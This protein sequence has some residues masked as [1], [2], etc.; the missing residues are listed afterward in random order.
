M[1]HNLLSGRRNMSSL[2]PVSAANEVEMET[3]DASPAHFLIKFDSFSFL[4]KR[5]IGKIVTREFK[6]GKY[7]WRLVIYPNGHGTG[8][9]EESYVSVYLA[10]ADTYD[11]PSNWEVTAFFSICLFDHVSGKYRYSIGRARRFHAL[12]TEWGFEKFISKKNLT[13]PSNGYIVDDKCVLGAEVFVN[14]NKAVTQCLSGKSVAE[15]KILYFSTM[16]LFRFL[17]RIFY[18]FMLFHL[19]ILIVALVMEIGKKI[20]SLAE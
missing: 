10:I 5:G 6:S 14:E 13:D 11:L 7:K 8:K 20:E 18:Y 9:D 17:K 15:F 3:R 16:K 1:L 12:K 19:F 4:H 2:A